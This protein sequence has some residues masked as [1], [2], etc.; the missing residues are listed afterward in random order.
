MQ[1]WMITQTLQ[2]WWP[3]LL[4]YGLGAV[5]GFQLAAGHM[6]RRVTARTRLLGWITLAGVVTWLVLHWGAVVVPQ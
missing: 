2:W 5:W 4:G 3:V 6:G 1:A